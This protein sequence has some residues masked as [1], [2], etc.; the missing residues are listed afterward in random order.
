MTRDFPGSEANVLGAHLLQ[1]QTPGAAAA[2]LRPSAA[3][4]CAPTAPR[5]VNASSRGRVA[6]KGFR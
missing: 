3:S 4:A 5:A 1:G 6:D 2:I